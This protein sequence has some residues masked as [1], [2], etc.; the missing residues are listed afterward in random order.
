MTCKFRRSFDVSLWGHLK[1]FVYAA[2]INNADC[3]IIFSILCLNL[4]VLAVY[5]IMYNHNF[6]YILLTYADVRLRID[7]H[8]ALI[9]KCTQEYTFICQKNDTDF[10]NTSAH[11]KTKRHDSK[12][13]MFSYT[14]N[15]ML[16]RIFLQRICY[17]YKL[18]DTW[19]YNLLNEV[20]SVILLLFLIF[21]NCEPIYFC[22][23]T[24]FKLLRCKSISK[25][26]SS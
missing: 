23:L 16:L 3:F 21:T 8:T 2:D 18:I 5:N 19:E 14:I 9:Y 15:M 17:R 22:I 7:E 13:I 1:Q 25:Q 12:Q 4:D 10:S 26:Y 24:A 11:N 20:D 6:I